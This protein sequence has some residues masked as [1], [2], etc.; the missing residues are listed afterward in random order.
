LQQLPGLEGLTLDDIR[1]LPGF[2]QPVDRPM[3]IPT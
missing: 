3:G 1:R 2:P